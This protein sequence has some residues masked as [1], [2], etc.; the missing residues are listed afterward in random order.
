MHTGKM[1]SKCHYPA[2]GDLELVI[3]LQQGFVGHYAHHY[4]AE[5]RG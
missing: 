4:T 1:G 2:H 3:Q 5:P